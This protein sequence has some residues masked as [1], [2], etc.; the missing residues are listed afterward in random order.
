[1]GEG[2]F[3]DA[4]PKGILEVCRRHAERRKEDR[5][6]EDWR[7]G[8]I[9]AEVANANQKIEKQGGG[10]WFPNDFFPNLPK[11]KREPMDWRTMKAILG[12]WSGPEITNQEDG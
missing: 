5:L 7:A 3:W 10:R 12:G 6:L 9:A 2:S 11:P 8:T 1:M 4:S